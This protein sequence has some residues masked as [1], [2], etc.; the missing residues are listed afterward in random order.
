LVCAEADQSIAAPWGCYGDSLGAVGVVI[1]TG[2]SNTV[3]I[4]TECTTSGT[5]ADICANLS[6][7]GHSDWF[8]PSKN[9]TFEMY[10]ELKTDG[11]ANFADTNY[12]S[13][14]EQSGSDFTHAS[15]RDFSE[16]SGASWGALKNL[17]YRVRAVRAF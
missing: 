5:A 10:T 6:L 11:I 16:G 15:Q 2:S 13:S 8:L 17:S 3:K 9:E 4:E 12:W 7:N 14:T 1:G